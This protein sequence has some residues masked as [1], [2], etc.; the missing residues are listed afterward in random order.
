MQR[1]MRFLESWDR[2]LWLAGAGL[3]LFSGMAMASAVATLN[4]ALAI[5]HALWI[6]TGL[7]ASCVVA[8]LN[9]RRW[10]DVAWLAYAVSLL[11]L[12]LVLAAG[13]VR[14]GATRWLSIFGLSL[15][16]SE[17][18]KLTMIWLLARYFAGQP[19][20][21]PPRVFWTSLV[22]A[23]PPALLILAQPDIGSASIFAT[24]WLGMA[25]IAGAP[26]RSFF[27]LAG[28]GLA[29]LPLGWH[30][31]R[32]YQRVRLMAFL[33]PQADPLGA[34]FSIIQ[35]TIAIGSGQLT[36][37]GWFA[38]TQNQLNF[39][40]ERHSDFIFSVIGEEWG[41]LGSVA[42]VVLFGLIL[43]RVFRIALTTSDPQGQLLASGV[44]CW[45]AYQA[46][47]NIGMVMGLLPVVGVPLPLVSYGGTSMVTAWVALGLLQSI[48][49]SNQLL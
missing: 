15:Q 44:F 37:R 28:G 25:W 35:S 26:R 13:V 12:L 30:V 48:H 16:P 5:R 31:L 36:G 47:V 11:T 7:L 46:F 22:F 34:G 45:L 1:L 3:A 4:P 24:I 18:A 23:G 8:S 17:L 32:D 33:N 27:E 41:F 19:S 21:L 14:L 43:H 6:L 38:G 2:T 42:V 40:P 9:Y 20:P 29:L 10:T 39:L 49:R